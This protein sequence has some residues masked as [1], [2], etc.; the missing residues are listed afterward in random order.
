MFN[1]LGI[2]AICGGQ[3]P[4]KADYWGDI[5]GVQVLLNHCL[6]Q[7][8]HMIERFL[9]WRL[10]FLAFNPM[11]YSIMIRFSPRKLAK[12]TTSLGAF[13]PGILLTFKVVLLGFQLVHVVDEGSDGFRHFF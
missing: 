11:R 10:P 2:A 4:N 6:N 9:I 12:L 5:D 13:S 3:S 1:L 8:D 7:C